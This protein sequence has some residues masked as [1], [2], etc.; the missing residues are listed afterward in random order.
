[1]TTSN[2]LYAGAALAITVQHPVIGILAALGS[3]FVLDMLPHYG[4]SE[5]EV[6]KWFRYR[7]TWFV[8]GMNII[9]VPLLV[10]LLWGQPWW[11]F[12]AAALAILP[13][14]VW[15]FRY[16]YYERYGMEASQ[17]LLTRFHDKI[18]WGERPW[19]AFVEVPCFI[20]LVVL[21]VM[22]VY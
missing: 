2:H 18:Q 4:R 9:G 21:L 6:A 7:A 13:D 14:V 8:E 10:Y 15:V 20:G 1:M 3:H 17:Y 11:V 12:A 19:G 22:M 5:R 16:F